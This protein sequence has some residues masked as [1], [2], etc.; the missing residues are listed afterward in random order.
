[1]AGSQ[2]ATSP[3]EIRAGVSQLRP[4]GSQ[5]RLGRAQFATS[6]AKFGTRLLQLVRDDVRPP[7]LASGTTERPASFPGERSHV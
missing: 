3:G 6:L 1:V 4:N 5:L 2:L 7:D